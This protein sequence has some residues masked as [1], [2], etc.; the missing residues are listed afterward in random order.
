VKE[1]NE[2]AGAPFWSLF[3]FLISGY[4]EFNFKTAPRTVTKSLPT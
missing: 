3:V 1:T 2:Y 4:K